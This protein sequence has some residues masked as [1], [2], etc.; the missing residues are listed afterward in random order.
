MNKRSLIKIQNQKIYYTIITFAFFL[1]GSKHIA[2]FL[3]TRIILF[4]CAP[5]NLTFLIRKFLSSNFCTKQI[6]FESKKKKKT[7][8]FKKAKLR[9]YFRN[10]HLIQAFYFLSLR[11]GFTNGSHREKLDF[12]RLYEFLQKQRYTLLRGVKNAIHISWTWQM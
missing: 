1:L 8:Q 5:P 11:W 12:S 7:S 9:S 4:S 2:K 10:C 3:A 6:I